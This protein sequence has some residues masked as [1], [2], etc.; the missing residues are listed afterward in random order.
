MRNVPFAGVIGEFLFANE[1][2]RDA[3]GMAVD[4][5]FPQINALPGAEGEPSAAYGDTQIYRRQRCANMCRHVVVAFLRVYKQRVAI[6]HQSFEK[7][8]QIA[9][10]VRVGIFLDEERGRGMLQ[11]QGQ[12]AVLESILSNP[13]FKVA[14]EFPKPAT[15]GGQDQ[16]ME[17][18]S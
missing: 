2:E 17:G 7:G 8:L 6:G 1:M 10:H 13:L 9:L 11:M 12:Q 15:T 14:R 3:A 5:V 18:L 16:F 4:R